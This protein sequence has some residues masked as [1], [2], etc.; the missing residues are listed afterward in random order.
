MHASPDLRHLPATYAPRPVRCL[1]L[2]TCADWQL[3]VIGISVA[4]TEPAAALVAAAKARAAE[5][6]ATEPIMHETY[7]V[8]FLGIHDGRGSN[9][10][11]LDRWANGNELLHKIWISAKD[12]PA[13]LREPPVDFNSVCVWDL[14]A[15]AFEREA[16]VRCVL[17]NPDG[18]DLDAYLA[19]RMDAWV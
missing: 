16:W 4:G 15:Q 5:Y 11:F 12:T 10:V 18:P 8:G 17:A 14:A 1:E 9:Q 3:K 13:A 6:L 7:G 2:F 19:A